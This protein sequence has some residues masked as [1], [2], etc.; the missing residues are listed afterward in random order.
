MPAGSG[1]SGDR[2]RDEHGVGGGRQA[3][4]ALGAVLCVVV[5]AASGALRLDEA[6]GLFDF[7][8]DENAALGYLERVYADNGLVVSR[9][10][11]EDG[12]AWIPENASYR[13]VMGS[14]IA[15]E[16]RFTRL[17]LEDFLRYFLLP[18][19]LTES[20]SAPWVFCYGC[21]VSSLGER[22]RVLS[23]NGDGILF[24]RTAP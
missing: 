13:V 20:D 6:L 5:A 23:D 10:V 14:R 2:F 7:R 21:D 4:V 9:R 15:G 16:H 24:G 18:R 3:T 19:R 1:G 12:L 11:V 8:A 22:F 17:V